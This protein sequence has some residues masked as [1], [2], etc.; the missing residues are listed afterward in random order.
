MPAEK[1]V[2]YPNGNEDEKEEIVDFMES[3]VP[4]AVEFKKE[5]ITDQKIKE[6]KLYLFV[7]CAFFAGVLLTYLLLKP[8]KEKKKVIN[9]HFFL[10]C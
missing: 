1:I 10:I 8:K 5:P 2:V 4:V 3:D 9:I 7:F 6:T